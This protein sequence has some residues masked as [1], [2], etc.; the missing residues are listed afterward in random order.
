MELWFNKKVGEVEQS[1]TVTF[2]AKSCEDC[3][4]AAFHATSFFGGEYGVVK[5]PIREITPDEIKQAFEK[6]KNVPF[7]TQSAP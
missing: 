6:I 1:M 2:D 5:K 3:A 7:S 4:Q